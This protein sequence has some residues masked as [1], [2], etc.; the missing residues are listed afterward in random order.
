MKTSGVIKVA[1]RPT[2][3][4]FSRPS[5]LIPLPNVRSSVTSSTNV[6]TASMS[7]PSPNIVCSRVTRV[8]NMTAVI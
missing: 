4:P 3:T 6:R 1:T 5:E 8:N 7:K 2:Q